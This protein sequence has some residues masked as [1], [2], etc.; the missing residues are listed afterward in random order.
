M[1]L[2]RPN[3][4]GFISIETFLII[5]VLV[6]VGGTGYF[7]YHATKKTSDTFT[8]AAK[9][10][11]D[12]MSGKSTKPKPLYGSGEN[13]LYD[14]SQ[15]ATT[16][17][18]KG[19]VKAMKANCDQIFAGLLSPVASD[20]VVV[21]GSQ[22]TFTDSSIYASSGGFAR[23]SAQ[24][25]SIPVQ[26][27]DGGGRFTFRKVGNSWQYLFGGQAGASCSDVDN[28]HVPPVIVDTCYD[29]NTNQTRAP[30]F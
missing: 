23:L 11:D 20:K 16:S 13:A 6:L 4:K 9:A 27:E 14:L 21:V 2:S 22:T 26:P 3:Q 12:T 1:H 7:V 18:Q 8:A 25:S 30:I 24:C 15:L 5:V 17:D 28:L 29:D 10:A 19:V